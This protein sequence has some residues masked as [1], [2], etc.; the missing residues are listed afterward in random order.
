MFG[1]RIGPIV[2]A[3]VAAVAV[4]AIMAAVRL[5]RPPAPKPG[6]APGA[7]QGGSPGD[8]AA[9]GVEPT[10]SLYHNDT[11]RTERI[12]LEDYVAGV[13][14]GEI[15]NDWPLETLKAQAILARTFTLQK[16]MK[17][18]TRH[19]TDA[20]TDPEEF[21]A[22][23]PDNIN[24]AIRRAVRETRGLVL[25][26]R[27][28]PIRAYFHSC[29]GGITSTAEEGLDFREEPTPYIKIV[30]EPPCPDPAKQRWSAT[31][32]KQEVAAAAAKMG[33]KLSDFSSIRVADRGP[34][35]RATRI[36][37]G[38]AV[39][40][41]AGLR[42]ALDPER[43]RSTLLESLRLEGDRVV[44]AGRG[45]GHGVGMSQFG[46]LAKA[47]QGWKAERIVRHYFRDV[48]LEKRW[49]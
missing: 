19:G 4:L 10:L 2:W 32:T 44:M 35:G 7:S 31:F 29:S 6:P 42:A 41:A 24:D 45:W 9:K 47:R 38:D 18:K 5:S 28:R 40:G 17:G 21:Q 12:K 15:K 26:Y 3:A 27:G 23:A 8:D 46:A 30:R 36:A 39:V 33:V 16:M 34:S 22:Y 1:N 14:G 25:T 43:M 20:S 48:R 49:R 13:V 11:G 37:L